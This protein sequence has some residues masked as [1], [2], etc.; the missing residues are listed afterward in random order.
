MKKKGTSKIKLSVILGYIL[1]VIVMTIGLIA[2]Y[3]NLVDFSN[4]RIR[5][6]DMSELLIVGNTLSL[7]YEVESEQNLL[8]AESARQYFVIYDSVIPEV[9]N[10][11]DRLKSFSDDDSRTLKLD[12]ISTL[13]KSKSA[14]LFEIASLLDSISQ[15]PEIIIE[16]DNRYVPR[17]LNKEITDYLESNNLNNLNAAQSDTSII[18][19]ERK[20]FFDRVRDVFI[21]N[22]DSTIV[23]ENRSVVSDNEFKLIVDTIINKVRFSERLDLSRQREFHNILIE[24]QEVMSHNNRMLTARIDELLKNIEQ[25]EIRKSFL[26]IRERERTL[27][28]SQNTMLLV[29]LLSIVIAI[30]FTLLFL[31]DINRSQRYRTQL[32][33]SNKRV[34]DLLDYREK[35]MLTISHDIKAPTGSIL[36]FIDLM[37][38]EDDAEKNKSYL[39]NMKISA[40]HVLQL[41]SKLLD[42]HKLDKGSWQ[43]QEFHFDIYTLIEESTNSFMPLAEKK[44]LDYKVDNQIPI[45]MFCYGDSYVLRQI[46]NNLISN[47]VKYTWQGG[48]TVTAIIKVSEDKNVLVFSVADTGEGIDIEDQKTIFNEFKQIK[49]ISE[50]DNR[51]EGSGLGL[52]ITKGFVK[53]LNGD[54]H[55]YS[56]K[57][58][59]SEFVVKIPLKSM[60]EESRGFGIDSEEKDLEDVFLLYVDDDIIQL[61]MMSEIALKKK[62]NCVI[63]SNP[64]NVL[65]ILNTNKFDILFIDIQLGGKSGFDLVNK[66]KN[67]A[68][69]LNK[70]T[71]IIALSARSDI[72]RADVQTFGFTDFMSKPFNINQIYELIR[73]Y[74]K[75]EASSNETQIEGIENNNNENIKPKGVSAIYDFV[76]DDT[77]VSSE[78]LKSFIMEAR[79]C[80]IVYK[81]AFSNDDIV[82]AGNISHKMLPL[83]RM[84]GEERVVNLMEQL[85]NHDQ[86]N[87]E[88]KEYLLEA[89]KNSIIEGTEL[90]RDL[91]NE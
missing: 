21:A 2:L 33:L 27:S 7:L 3:N 14:N 41:V 4:K 18:A 16:S 39:N 76:K 70:E 26:L 55:L 46:V 73:F 86:L 64:D 44:G 68:N 32:E 60:P 23:I 31:I 25:E 28:Q 19:G 54:L 8:T 42:Y 61:K 58:I 20:G 77:R 1:V 15:S 75:D 59:G 78:I 29:S 24:K 84:I 57:D 47:A 67:E 83:F 56:T 22:P 80:E 69:I 11:L 38:E 17:E 91:N 74:V 82:K 48:V 5:N 36:G 34:M 10:N 6:E 85:E 51:I 40:E 62:I 89:I 81:D 88:D 63:E 53:E 37:T 30:F 45:K 66:I 71:P 49:S 43:L 50:N 52:A 90:I 72:S 65:A 79:E 87:L 12:S 35:M 13:M 9:K